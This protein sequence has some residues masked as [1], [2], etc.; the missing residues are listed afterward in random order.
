M[1]AFRLGLFVTA[2]SFSLAACSGSEEDE[3]RTGLMVVGSSTVFPFAQA[4]A[5]ATNA[6]NPDL[7]AITV[8]STGTAAGIEAFCS[9]NTLDAPD[10]V[11]ASR[12]MTAQEFATCQAN[13]VTSIMELR[14]GTDGVVFVT[15][16][17]GG[18]QMNLT[19]AQIYRALA[20]EPYGDEQS[21]AVWSDIDPSLPG[22]T[23][24]VYGPAESSGTRASL[25]E[26]V[27][28]DGC[29]AD[30]RMGGLQLS[31]PERFVQVCSTLRSDSAFLPQG[32]DDDLIV[33]KVANNEH[34]I[35]IVGYSWFEENQATVRALTIDG[36]A[37][38]AE[39]I[40]SGSYPASRPLY[41]YVNTSRAEQIPGLA[42]YVSQWAASW[43]ADGPLARIGLVVSPEADMATAAAT[44]RDM[45]L[46]T[47]DMLA[48]E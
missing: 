28:E 39:T 16:A 18:L 46:L 41:I 47:A 8:E 17:D 45:T 22:E 37:P 42:P 36:V 11:N 23:I 10:V 14:V 48:P 1:S 25:L 20:A 31:E 29:A 35:A 30:S 24:E 44:A 26:L 38:T 21:A 19:E 13:G 2:A 3:V 9:G 5:Q 15:S 34:A 33:R 32:E 4:V 6:A 43:G 40:A 27:L 12:R 7:A